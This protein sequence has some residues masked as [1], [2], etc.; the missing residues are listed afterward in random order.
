MNRR[1]GVADFIQKDRAAIGDFKQPGFI[2]HRPG[3][4]P[5]H[6]PKQFA[7]EQGLRHGAAI[8]RHKRHRAPGTVIVDRARHQLF[9]RSAFPANQHIALGICD[10]AHH[11]EHLLH[12]LTLSDDLRK[13]RLT[14]HFALQEDIFRRESPLLQ[15]VA[16]DQLHF[17]DLEGLGQVVIRAL[18][19]RIDRRVRSRKRRKDQNDSFR[20]RGL[21]RLEDRHAVG[22]RHAKVGDH[23]IKNFSIHMTDGLFAVRGFSHGI[24]SPCEHDAQD[25]AETSLV[26]NN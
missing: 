21:H 11:I 23:E 13:R 15:S 19:H 22:F 25:L 10:L 3:K 16:D 20:R 7:F 8:H 14:R 5:L 1:G 4:R 2:G 17:I 12:A 18:F 6:V 24:T 9:T 26:I